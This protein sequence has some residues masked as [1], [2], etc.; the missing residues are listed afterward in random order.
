MN[1]EQHCIA[2]DLNF[3]KLGQVAF[4]V[5]IS[6]PVLGHSRPTCTG[7]H[8]TGNG[9][10]YSLEEYFIGD[11]FR[12]K[13]EDFCIKWFGSVRNACIIKMKLSPDVRVP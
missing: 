9:S 6:A 4:S 12:M 5:A 13:T 8:Y 3:Q 1:E 11:L 10:G 2:L 7:A